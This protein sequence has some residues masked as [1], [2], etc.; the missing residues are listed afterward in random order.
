MFEPAYLEWADELSLTR[1]RIGQLAGLAGVDE[2]P[3]DDAVDD[4]VAEAAIGVLERVGD[5]IGKE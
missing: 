4:D 5:G 1:F 3:D 2:W